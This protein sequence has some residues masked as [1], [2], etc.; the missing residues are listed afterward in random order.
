VIYVVANHAFGNVDDLVVH[1]E[2]LFLFAAA[3]ARVAKCVVRVP[4]AVQLPFVLRKP[5][6]IIGVHDGVFAL[7]HGY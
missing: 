7:A 1:P 6:V 3:G 5:I 2:P 4:A